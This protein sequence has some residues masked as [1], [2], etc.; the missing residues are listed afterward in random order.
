MSTIINTNVASMQARDALKVNGRA[1][2][3]AMEQLSTGQRVNSASDDAAGLAISV[4][5]S[6]QARSLTTAVRN[7]NDGI[8]LAQTAEG[9][10]IEVSNML[11]RM[12]E[13][14]VQASTETISAGQR[15]Y[16]SNE[17]VALA[18]Q[19]DN[20]ISNTKWNGISV[21]SEA[22]MDT[23]GIKIQVGDTAGQELV[24]KGASLT[25]AKEATVIPA[26]WTTQA[27]ASAGIA[28]ID[29]GLSAVNN[30]R[31]NLGVAIN[32]LTSIGDNL[33][34]IAQNLTESRSRIVDTDYAAATAEMARTMIIQQAGTAVLAQANQR[35]QLVLALLR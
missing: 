23:A 16:L 28:L 34:N 19:I 7:A 13:L 15:T 27:L 2:A 12:R 9:A 26:A 35:P 5:M 30:A 25:A 29:G 17:A 22:S 14:A 33:T 3:N 11:Q 21:L 20:T 31:A 24:V 6:T 10:L 32:R 1:M 18:K 4:A 8:S